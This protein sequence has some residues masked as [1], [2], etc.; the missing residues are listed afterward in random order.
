MTLQFSTSVEL[1]PVLISEL[2]PRISPKLCTVLE[3]QNIR[4]PTRPDFSRKIPN[5][6]YKQFFVKNRGFSYFARKWL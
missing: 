5:L 2:A 3:D 6:F 4:Y 1:M